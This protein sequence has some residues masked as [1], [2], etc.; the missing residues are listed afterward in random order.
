MSLGIIIEIRSFQLPLEFAKPNFLEFP[1]YPPI[2]F[3]NVV[4]ISD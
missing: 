2:Y 1:K 3:E 4:F